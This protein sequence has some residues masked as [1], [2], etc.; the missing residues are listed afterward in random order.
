MSQAQHKPLRVL[1]LA[2]RY[3]P[4][5]GGA[6]THAYK[7]STYLSAR[8]P[9]T[10]VALRQASIVHLAWY[11]PWAWLRAA[12]ALILGRVDIVYFQD[13]V[14]AS[15]AT[16]LAPFRGRARFCCSLYGLEMTFGSRW[17]QALMKA[18]VRRCD[19]IAVISDNSIRIAEEAW[20]I[21]ASRMR[22]IYLGAEP[23]ELAPTRDTELREAFE[24]EHDINF[25]CDRV[26]LN[27]GRQ[28][29]R[30]GVAAFV[31]QGLDL[32]D[33]DITVLIVGGGPDADRIAAGRAQLETSGRVKILGILDDDVCSMLRR[34]CGLFLMPNMATPGDVEGYGIA[35]LEAMYFGTHV[36]AFAVDALVEAV[37][38]G[39]WLIAPGDYQAF[40][41]AVH[42]FFALSPEQRAQTGQQARDYCLREYG[43]DTTSARYADIFQ[44]LCTP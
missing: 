19:G 25:E 11:M 40:A 2:R 29:T 22:L 23:E 44:E 10:L 30:K 13:G 7:L 21:P 36:V 39:G 1:F 24:Q 14:A 32:L 4:T 42:A 26:V 18:G 28:V 20:G 35:P 16:A 34:H 38:E 15:L 12:I 43:W 9:V 37:R 41:D 17:A 5:R 27:L 33:P 8:M 3:P 6:Q 31:E